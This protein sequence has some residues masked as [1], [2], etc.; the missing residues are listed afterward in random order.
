MTELERR[1]RA[2]FASRA[3]RG[4]ILTD[5]TNFFEAGFTSVILAAVRAD[6][7]G[8][9]LS[10]GM[11]DMFRYPTLA[12]LIEE[13]EARAAAGTGHPARANRAAAARLPWDS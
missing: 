6:L 1:I 3:P 5:R 7:D 9:G 11:V 2:A 10:L 8:A 4:R 12:T 13:V